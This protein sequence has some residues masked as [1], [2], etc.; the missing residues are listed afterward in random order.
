MGNDIRVPE[1]LFVANKS[2]DGFE[3]D[4]LADFY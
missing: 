2:E 3:G 1:I 4:L